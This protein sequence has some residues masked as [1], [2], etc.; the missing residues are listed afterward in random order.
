LIKL[1]FS[2]YKD[3]D[4]LMYIDN[5]KKTL[6]E[7][8][9]E[10]YSKFEEYACHYHKEILNRFGIKKADIKKQL[11]RFKNGEASEMSHIN[12]DGILY[13]LDRTYGDNG[14]ADVLYEVK[15]GKSWRELLIKTTSDLSI[16]AELK[17]DHLY[18]HIRVLKSIIK[19]ILRFCAATDKE[20]TG[21]NLRLVDEILKLAVDK[22]KSN[23]HNETEKT[24]VGSIQVLVHRTD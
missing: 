9:D 15:R 5:L 1:G 14:A 23:E 3:D 22:Q 20:Q 8:D 7:I 16:P 19:N 10:T 13:A 4:V 6:N 18:D 11:K 12:L 21:S 2:F 24:D 17:V